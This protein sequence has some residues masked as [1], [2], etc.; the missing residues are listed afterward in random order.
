MNIILTAVT[1]KNVNM[2]GQVLARDYVE[3]ILLPLM[4]A[5]RGQNHSAIINVVQTFA[6][7]GL[8]TKATRDGTQLYQQH[9]HDKKVQLAQ[10]QAE[11]Q[12]NA[13]RCR[14]LTPQELQQA[15]AKREQY[16]AEVRAHGAA[17]RAARGR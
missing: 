11:A 6:E 10:Q 13:E 1:P 4:V 16:A 3:S 8:N 17:L 5:S 14:V 7:A 12:A 2:N 15:H 9:L